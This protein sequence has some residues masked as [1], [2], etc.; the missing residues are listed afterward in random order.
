MGRSA[1]HSEVNT[2]DSSVADMRP[3]VPRKPAGRHT[4]RRPFCLHSLECKR[5]DFGANNS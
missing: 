4:D 1:R 5:F 3:V 2:L